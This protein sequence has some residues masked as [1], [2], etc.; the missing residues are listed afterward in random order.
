MSGMLPG[1]ECARRRRLHNKA[2]SRDSTNRSSL[3]LYST[4]KLQSPL[5][6]RNM[7]NQTDSDENLGGA[8][9]EAKRRLDEK[10]AGLVKPE[11]TPQNKGFFSMFCRSNSE[12]R[13]LGKI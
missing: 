2:S 1:V 10:L 6:E 7:V 8:A 12:S 9:R 11:N 3:C 13:D 4:R 5:L